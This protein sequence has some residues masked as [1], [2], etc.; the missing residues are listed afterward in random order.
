MDFSTLPFLFVFFSIFLTIWI[1]SKPNFRPAVILIASLVFIFLGQQEA[2]LPLV[3]I[4]LSGY[5][6]GRA[7]EASKKAEKN[8]SLVLWVGAILILAVLFFQKWWLAYGVKSA[9]EEAAKAFSLLPVL[10]LSYVAF[11]MI[12]YLIDISRGSIPAETSIFKFGS[13][14]LFFPKLVSGPL[15]RYKPFR[16]QVSNLTPSP[17]DIA[18]GI[19]RIL[20][21]VVKRLLIANQ[22]G[23]V[24]NS[25][26]GLDAPN[27]QPHFA[28]LGLIAYTFQIY[29]DF[30]GYTD[31]A[32]G[33]GR[34]MGMTLPENFN[35]PYTAQSI[36]DFWRR[37]HMTLSAWFREYVFF[38]LERRRTFLN[39][40]QVNMIIVFVLTGLWHGL[41]L[42]FIIWGGIHG[43]AIALESLGGG[44]WMKSI[45]QPIRHLT[46]MGLV[47]LGWIFFRSNSVSFAFGFIGRLFGNV[48]G[49]TP[50][51]FS[52]T[53][54]LP[55]I[56]PSFVIILAFAAIFSLP[57]SDIWNNAR[58]R[59]ADKPQTLL[60]FQ[61]AE[62]ALI[63]GLF[64]LAIASSLS[65][66]FQPNIYAKF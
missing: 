9:P 7:V 54:P 21:G 12:S 41:T 24:A 14:L 31:I 64:A 18:A 55:F 39:P 62:D 43:I 59:F 45:W 42:N 60:L 19:R 36:G 13:Y 6:L 47:M 22:L 48:E 63:I 32:I 11:Q 35:F 26:F 44:K 29:F 25:V 30:S 4:T 51:P 23:L 40:Q 65:G 27:I 61:I 17:E 33:L 5:G 50:L 20:S 28:W 46:T 10:G 37:W 34:I 15:M 16:E 66:S 2:L 8:A 58:K 49:I 3:V 57:V 38:P 53:T 1:V 56:E 52:Q